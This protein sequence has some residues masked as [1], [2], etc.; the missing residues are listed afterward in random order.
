[1]RQSLDDVV[2]CI[3]TKRLPPVRTLESYVPPDGMLTLII[4]D[5]SV[6]QQHRRA[7]RRS[8]RLR[9]IRVVM[10]KAG[11]IPQVMQCYR[12]ARKCGY[13]YFFRLDDDLPP[14]TF[15]KKDRSHPSLEQV[16]RWARKCIDVCDVSLAG[17]GNTSRIDWLGKGY[18]RSYALVHGGAQICE[19][20]D[21]KKFAAVDPKLPRYE[22]VYRSLSHRRRDGAVGRVKFVGL[23]KMGSQQAATGGSVAEVSEKKRKK[24]ISIIE[25]EFAPEFVRYLGEKSVKG[26]KITYPKFQYRRHK[27]FSL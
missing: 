26:G 5:P 4:A 24:A 18:G 15:I 9:G 14:N 1:M 17:F 2:I 13:K 21:L 16:I 8:K 23:N 19:A 12:W 25:R 10:G 22:D 3:P 7:V 11:L 20:L 6:Y 27:D